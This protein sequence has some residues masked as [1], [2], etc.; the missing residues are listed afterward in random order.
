MV[1]NTHHITHPVTIHTLKQ[2]KHKG[3]KFVCIALYDAPTATIAQ[4]QGIEVLLVG[5]SLGMTVQGH[6]ST[7]PVT[8]EHMAYHTSA[9][10]RG[11]HKS[12]IIADMPFMSYSTTEQA[13]HNAGLLMQAGANIVKLE[14]G[15]W[16]AETIYKL[17]ERGIPV[18]AH[19]G[20]TP[21]SVNKFGGFR[22]Q[23]KEQG[24]ADNILK[25]AKLLDQAGADLIVLECIPTELAT[26]ITQSVKM[27]TIGIGAGQMTDAQ[28]LVINDIIGL[29]AKPPRF[30]KNFLSE[31]GSIAEAMTLFRD[32]VKAGDFPT[33]NHTFRL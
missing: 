19:L 12:L 8:M 28:V 26:T 3:D 23:G 6:S 30:S 32:Q 2:L 18:C 13:M 4:N 10:S 14:G 16:L 5:D 9:V 22:V 17:S 27:S 24:Q 29:T 25:D 15:E 31:A 20:L 33:E 21:Q 7:L 1:Y 11:N